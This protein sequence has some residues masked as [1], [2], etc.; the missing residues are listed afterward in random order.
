MP[1][2]SAVQASVAEPWFQNFGASQFVS[3]G[4]GDEGM[5]RSISVT[6]GWSATFNRDGPLVVTD[7]PKSSGS[8]R[9][10]AGAAERARARGV[11]GKREGDFMAA[12]WCVGMGLV[13][14]PR[15]GERPLDL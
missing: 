2:F 6:T 11:S 15:L 5:L 4:G 3:R 9:A 14:P 1:R 7:S 10:V 12:P 13:G 8:C